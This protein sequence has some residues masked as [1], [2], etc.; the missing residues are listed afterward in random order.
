MWYVFLLSATVMP[1]RFKVF[2]TSGTSARRSDFPPA[3]HWPCCP[4][5]RLASLRKMWFVFSLPLW[6]FP[7]RHGDT[8]LSL[9]GLFHGNSMD[10]NWGDPYDLGKLHLSISTIYDIVDGRNPNNPNHQLIDGKHPPGY[11]PCWF[12]NKCGNK[13]PI[14]SW[15]IINVFHL[16]GPM[17]GI[18]NFEP[19]SSNCGNF[20]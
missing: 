17:S 6:E 10:E 15:H 2:W 19:S 16:C 13:W 3:S 7:A 9:D 20:F 11:N 12:H 18:L 14:W 4:T 1:V 5:L 8:P